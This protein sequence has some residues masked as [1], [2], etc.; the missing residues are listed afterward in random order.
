MTIR[1]P[2]WRVALAA[3]F[4]LAGAG[5]WLVE[6]VL[7]IAAMA[8]LVFLAYS[9]L[10]TAPPAEDVVSLERSIRP[11]R[12]YPGGTITVR[13]T[14]TN[15]SDRQLLDCR[16]VDGVPADL[17]VVDGSPRAGI[18]LEPDET[19]ALEYTLRARYGEFDFEPVI[20]RTHSVS[21]ARI[22]TA[23]L[24]ADGDGRI[25][26]TL[27]P[28]SYV[29]GEQ[30]TGIAGELTVD[31][32]GQGLEFFG[33]REYHPEDPMNRI[34]WRQYAR[35]RQLSTVDYRQQEA[36]EVVVVVDARASTRVAAGETDPTG[37]E[38]CIYLANEAITGLLRNRNRVG[39]A[40]LGVD[41]TTVDAVGTATDSLTLVPPG[42]GDAVRAR[43]R[44]LLDAAAATVSPDAEPDG[45]P[46]DPVPPLEIIGRVNRRTQIILVTPLTDDYPVE[47]ARQL[48]LTGNAVSIYTPVIE[49][50][51]S[52]GGRVAAAAR[53]VRLT[54][55]RRVG[56]SVVDWN[57]DEPLDIAFDDPTGKRSAVLTQP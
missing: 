22:E 15:R 51:T 31:R 19:A 18:R 33:I 53:T 27:D 47:L 9:T 4:V 48:R 21:A 39:A 54:R 1:I 11:A 29:L 36:V 30:T 35:D 10:S 23:H 49:D 3:T 45:T 57:P 17:G 16:I 26:A 34:N 40:V 44:A 41:G 55:L 42:S 5:V 52:A 25:A 50:H 8:P 12:T 28:E 7:L 46:D 20:V 24:D 14:I 6:P 38:L 2:R 56:A 32:G 37:T 13:L 43:I